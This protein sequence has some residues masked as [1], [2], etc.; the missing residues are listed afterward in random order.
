MKLE[1]LAPYLPYKL[2]IKYVNILVM[3][4]GQGSSLNWIGINAVI[5][6][7]GTKEGYISPLPIL[8]PLS[9]LTKE[10]TVNGETIVPADYCNGSYYFS[11]HDKWVWNKILS[12]DQNINKRI[13]ELPYFLITKLISWHF[14]VFGLIEKGEAVDINTI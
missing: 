3:N 4:A 7:Q 13:T 10:I 6:R 2:K 1:H 5:Q 9:D 8:R 14:D 11:E 12:N